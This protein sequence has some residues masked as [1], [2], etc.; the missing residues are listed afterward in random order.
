ML[1]HCLMLV[2]VWGGGG[3]KASVH[4][5]KMA[6]VSWNPKQQLS[7]RVFVPFA[8]SLTK[9]HFWRLWKRTGN[10]LKNVQW[11]EMGFKVLKVTMS[12]RYIWTMRNRMHK[13]NIRNER[14]MVWGKGKL[15]SFYRVAC[16]SL[17]Q[18]SQDIWFKIKCAFNIVKFAWKLFGKLNDTRHTTWF[19]NAVARDFVLSWWHLCRV[20]LIC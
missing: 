1:C 9:I 11:K 13:T 12:L 18:N 19:S 2:Y 8:P 15:P 20:G 6:S 10:V 5:Y 16:W 17:L 7:R 3:A 4:V 14:F